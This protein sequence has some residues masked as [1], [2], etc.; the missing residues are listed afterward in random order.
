MMALSLFEPWAT[1]M[2][3]GAKK[4]ETRSWPTSHRGR[5]LIHA[6]AKVAHELI[7][8]CHEEPFRTHLR[9]AGILRWQDFKL[10]AV[11]GSVHL[12]D[13][14]QIVD[15]SADLSDGRSMLAPD[16]PER[17][18]GLYE[19]G[20]WAWLCSQAQRFT[21]PI[22]YRGRQRIFNIP[23]EALGFLSER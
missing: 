12:D 19:L 1:L 15:V 11:I 23:P 10:G 7:E 17:S 20:R 18:F 22:P 8:I 9:A 5:L 21:T 2:C 13:C 3:I 4:I 16:E 14:R 6:G